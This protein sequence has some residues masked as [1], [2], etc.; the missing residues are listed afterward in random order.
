MPGRPSVLARIASIATGAAALWI[1]ALIVAGFAANGCQRRAVEARIARSLEATAAFDDSSLTLLRGGFTGTGLSITKQ[2]ALGSLRVRVDE[3]DADLA[4]FGIALADSRP[5]VLR[6]SGVELEATSLEILRVARRG[7]RP[8]AV[9]ALELRDVHF[10]AMPVGL[11]PG[12]GR[13]EVTISRARS[14]PTVLRT[15]LSWVF[16]LE[17]LTAAIALPGGVHVELAYA[18]GTLR[19]KGG[20]FGATAVELPFA[21]PVADPAREIEQLQSLALELAKQMTLTQ[22]ESWLDRGWDAVRSVVP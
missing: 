18:N 13:I 14:G 22:A 7:G 11:M 21:I 8:F 17:E 19:A 20:V 12:L 15:P 6:L 9:D 2:S 3:L 1:A 5:R 10:V 4:P 16:A